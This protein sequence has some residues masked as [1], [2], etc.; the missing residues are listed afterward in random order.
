[1]CLVVV[2]IIFFVGCAGEEANPVQAQQYDK[3]PNLLA[4]K[5][6]TTKVISIPPGARIELDN[7]YLGDAPLEIQWKGWPLAR[8]FKGDHK[9]NALPIYPG[10]QTQS[11][12]FYSNKRIPETILFQMNL[13][14]VPR[15]YEI[16][17]E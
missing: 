17:I 6:Y 7:D 11:K 10:Q 15:R 3:T 5:T 1:M 2:L 8:V 14:S 12:I 13:E 4:T 9:V 16:D